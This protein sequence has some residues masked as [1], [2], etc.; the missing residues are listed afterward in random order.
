MTGIVFVLLVPVIVI[1]V[2]TWAWRYQL[3]VLDLFHR[4]AERDEYVPVVCLREVAVTDGDEVDL[5]VEHLPSADQERFAV[6]AH[7]MALAT[8][9]RW[10]D[11]R[12]RLLLI[13]PA[14]RNIVRLRR[15]DGHEAL[16]LRRVG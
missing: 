15:R 8:L 9:R 14:G 7:G 13:V 4:A 3:R 10:H 16:T 1:L 12:A 11:G 5:V 6:D 2:G